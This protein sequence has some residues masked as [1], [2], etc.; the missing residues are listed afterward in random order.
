MP[1]TPDIGHAA[2]ETIL[3]FDFG[4]RRIG[5]AVGQSVTMSASPLGVVS[6]SDKGPD[7][8]AI[9]RLIHEWRPTRLVVG[10]PLHADGEP[11]E[12]QAH[13]EEFV[14]ELWRYNLDVDTVDER[15]TSI[16]AEE[17]LKKARAA[18]SRGRVSKEAI[19]SAAAVF[20]AERF[21][22]GQTNV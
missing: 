22:S 19:D 1:V 4:L 5:V 15:Y 9:D 12:M 18:G 16:E 11:G 13:V 20:I 10:L 2:P 21:L 14:R 3:A 7:F 6:N 8:E 17:A